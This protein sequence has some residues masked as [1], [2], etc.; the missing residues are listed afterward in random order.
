MHWDLWVQDML[1]LN[2]NREAKTNPRTPTWPGSTQI[3]PKHVLTPQC[4]CM[5]TTNRD[6]KAQQNSG[7]IT[8]SREIVGRAEREGQHM[9]SAQHCD[10]NELPEAQR[11]G[12]K[13]FTGFGSVLPEGNLSQFTPSR[14]C[15][16]T[17]H[18]PA[19]FQLQWKEKNFLKCVY[20][21]ASNF[22]CKADEINKHRA[23]AANRLQSTSA[24]N[25]IIMARFS[26]G[27][28]CFGQ[29]SSI[30]G[31]FWVTVKYT[32]EL[33]IILLSKQGKRL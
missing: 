2:P 17:S 24:A 28:G 13:A 6:A 20:L 9:D 32:K 7:N 3:S 16:F 27:M 14:G 33:Q 31:C 15:G 26:L 10:S 11:Q 12:K 5:G 25:I 18:F 1:G 19:I 23:E 22:H 30:T 8:Q 21:I 29:H 4:S